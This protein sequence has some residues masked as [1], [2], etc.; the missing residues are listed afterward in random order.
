MIIAFVIAFKMVFVKILNLFFLNF[1]FYV[2][3]L[4]KRDGIKNNFKN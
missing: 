1:F 3:G 4:F 2:F